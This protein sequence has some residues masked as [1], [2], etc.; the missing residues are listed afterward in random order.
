L[1][2]YSVWPNLVLA[3]QDIASTVAP[4]VIRVQT[5]ILKTITGP[6]RAREE[7]R[8]LSAA[9]TSCMD[10]R[11]DLVRAGGLIFRQAVEAAGA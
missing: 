5:L 8:S 6:R 10:H 2:S 4:A 1:R 7:L 3:I 9:A 11:L